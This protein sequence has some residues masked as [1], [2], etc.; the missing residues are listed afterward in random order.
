VKQRAAL[1]RQCYQ[2]ALDHKP[3][4][5]GKLIVRFR[6]GDDGIVVPDRTS[7]ADGT[8]LHDDDVEHCVAANIN[9]LKFP[10]SG[11]VANVKY[12]FLFIQGH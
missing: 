1:F 5:G 12:P 4:L 6:I 3:G 10:A 9:R 11:G 7:F 8:T 2:R